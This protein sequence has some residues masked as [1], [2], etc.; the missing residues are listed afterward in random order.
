[1]D[2]V[3]LLALKCSFCALAYL[4]IVF[5]DTCQNVGKEPSDT[6]ELSR[7]LSCKEHCASGQGN[8]MGE[9]QTNLEPVRGKCDSIA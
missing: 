7:S 5:T 2:I 8:G 3:Y 9:S 4:F 6:T 1:M